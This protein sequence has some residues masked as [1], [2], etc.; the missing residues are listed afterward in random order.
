MQERGTHSV[1]DIPSNEDGSW[2]CHISHVLAALHLRGLALQGWGA[3]SLPGAAAGPGRGVW[4][5]A[6]NT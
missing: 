1:P 2:I 4:Q 6:T 5:A 3:R